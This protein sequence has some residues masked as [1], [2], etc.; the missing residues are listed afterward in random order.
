MTVAEIKT[1]NRRRGNI[2]SQITKITKAIDDN[3]FNIAEWK[4]H[5]KLVSKVQEK[6]EIIKEEYYKII[7]K[8]DFEETK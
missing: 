2:K 1:L 8:E 4:V 3:A 6:V 5:L 7:D